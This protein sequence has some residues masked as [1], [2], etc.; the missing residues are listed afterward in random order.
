MA[1]VALIGSTTAAEGELPAADTVARLAHE[2]LRSLRRDDGGW[3]K[4]SRGG[5]SSTYHTFLAATLL[6]ML[7]ERLE[8]PKR[9]A[10][11]LLSRQQSD[12]GF[13]ELPPM[14][15]SGT[16]PTAAA[17]AVLRMTG[18]F[19]DSGADSIGASD[20]IAPQATV[21]PYP[22]AAQTFIG[23]ARVEKATVLEDAARF[24]AAMQT[25]EGGM[26]AHGRIDSADLLST[27]TALIA[28]REL[29][30]A[31]SIDLAAVR[32]FATGLLDEEGGFRAIRFDTASD[33]EYTFYGLGTLAMTA[34]PS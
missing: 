26:R 31:K 18:Q 33:V 4:S 7:G 24:L 17:V 14:T 9:T 27:F 20:G 8:T 1:S 3:A 21:D 30:H 5:P 19:V 22:G 29:G 10:A 25:V 6:E 23:S 13:V 12:G 32:R 16:N 15:R 28:L 34:L 11:M 2:V